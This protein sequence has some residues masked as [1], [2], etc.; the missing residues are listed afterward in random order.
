MKT[1]E[2]STLQMVLW[3]PSLIGV[4]TVVG[5]YATIGEHVVIGARCR[6]GASTVIDGWTRMGDH[7]EVFPFASIGLVPQDLK[8]KGEQTHLTIGSHNVFREFV[9][10]HRGTA[11]GGGSSVAIA[12]ASQSRRTLG[13]GASRIHG[14]RRHAMARL[15]LRQ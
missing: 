4:G 2:P 7:N 5:P 3:A 15:C 11:G 1:R 12:R 13:A 6:I 10:I 8:F 9:T 14:R